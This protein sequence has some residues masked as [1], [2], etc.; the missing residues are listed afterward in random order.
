M[1]YRRTIEKNL[2]KELS[3]L[4]RQFSI[5]EDSL[6]VM[7]LEKERHRN[8]LSNLQKA[9]VNLQIEDIKLYFAYLKGLEVRIEK[10]WYIIKK[11]QETVDN[12]LIEVVYA[13]KNRKILEVIKE[14][15]FDEY[16]RG[17]NLKE[18]RLLDEIAVNRF[19]R[20]MYVR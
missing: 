3:E 15:G 8:E 17:I 10:Q 2:I 4:K 13:M 16:R 20:D 5:E 18:Q 7:L 11:C 14:R 1:N 19:A 6:N 12:K 9:G